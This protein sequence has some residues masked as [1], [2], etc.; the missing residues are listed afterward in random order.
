MLQ[1]YLTLSAQSVTSNFYLFRPCFRSKGKSRLICKDKPLSYTR[2]KE[3]I[4]ARL[5]EVAFDLNLGLHYLRA[6]G[7][8]Y[9]ANS[10]VNDRCWKTQGRW[11][12]DKSKDMYVADSLD[13]HLAVSRWLDL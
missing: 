5:K 4:V 11:K 13:Q 12:S 7:A 2:A 8:T 3:C 9:A 1:H 6:G 10:G